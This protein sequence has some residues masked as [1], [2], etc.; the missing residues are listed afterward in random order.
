MRL[1]PQS[2]AMAAALTAL[3]A[4]A[5]ISTDLY[6]P[7]MPAIQDAFGVTAGDV[8][9]TL[10]VYLFGFAGAQL[11]MGP[12]SDRFGRRPVL[13]A[14]MS[15]YLAASVACILADSIAALV[16]GRFFQAAGACAGAAVGRAVVRDIHGLKDAARLLTHM[17]TA[18]AIAPLM[19]PFVG[20][21]LTAQFGW[22]SNF[23]ALAGV[24]AALLLLVA[25]LFPETHGAPDAMAM[26][27]RR[28]AANYGALI[29]DASYRD[30]LLALA[31]SFSGL[32]AF[33]SGSSFVLIGDLGMAPERFG[34]AFGAVVMGYIV[35]TQAAARF[36]LRRGVAH[37]I[38]VGG[39]IALLAGLACLLVAWTQPPSVAAVVAPMF[40]D[41]MSTG[42]VL[43]DAMAGAI[44]PVPRM[45]GAASAL[46]GFS[47]MSLA[48]LAGLLVGYL[49]DGTPLPMMAVI[50]A[51]GALAW[52]FTRRVPRH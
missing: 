45:A 47:Q 27:P 51:C 17:G 5:P 22:Q 46:L 19:A 2:F 15:L 10:S 18:M 20:G 32:F 44:G 28:M 36:F 24:G 4:V 40:W 8:Q 35:G 37:T 1:S 38:R 11:I 34:Y 7:A 43:P 25:A 16:A 31:F 41:P 49:H 39:R 23:W 21:Q 9:L 48:S 26:R 12:L 14:G 42:F 6:L 29:G 52:T 3:V 50:A 30:H 13:V 33:I